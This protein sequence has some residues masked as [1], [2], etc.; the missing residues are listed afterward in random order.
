MTDHCAEADLSEPLSPLWEHRMKT[1]NL[2]VFIRSNP[3]GSV[4]PVRSGVSG[5]K[6]ADICLPI[7][8]NE[9]P[10]Q[11]RLKQTGGSDRV[12]GAL[13]IYIHLLNLCFSE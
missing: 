11:I 9:W 8:D 7:E 3:L 2:S 12:K 10:D 6:S 5:H 4:D 13:H 1:D